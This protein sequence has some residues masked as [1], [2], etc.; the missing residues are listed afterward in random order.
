MPRGRPKSSHKR[1]H[2]VQVYLT[3]QELAELQE[4]AARLGV[5]LGDVI[6][7][8]LRLPL[9]GYGRRRNA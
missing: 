1:P 4:R 2:R 9:S 3:P 6:R 7:V 8:A 5:N